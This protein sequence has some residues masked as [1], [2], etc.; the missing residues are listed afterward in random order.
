MN[1]KISRPF[2][3]AELSGNHN[4]KIERA[5]KLLEAAKKAG[6]NAAKLQTYTADTL[7]I[8]SNEP[9]FLITQ[10]PWA[11][12]NL[13]KLY[14]EAHTPW[15]W[16]PELFSKAQEL[17]I[18]IFS[19]P[20]DETAVDYLEKLGVARYKI[21]SFEIVHLPL[22]KYAAQTKKPMIISTGMA[23]LEE[24]SDAV[25]TAFNN[26]CTNLT[27]LHCVSSYPAVTK[28]CNLLTMIDI[29]KHFPDV[30]IGLSDHTLGTTVSVAAVAL[31][32]EVIEKHITLARSEGGVDAAFSL[33]P[34]EFKEL[35][36]EV[37]DSWLSLGTVNYCRAQSELENKVFRRSIYAV[38]DIY[39]GERLTK[40]NIRIIRPGFGLEPKYFD[41]IVG[42][43][44][45]KTYKK[46][47]RLYI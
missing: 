23:N 13:Y 21:A 5:F 24:I 22:I 42:T 8:D 18:E 43:E 28:D 19:S 11:G 2:I 3:I 40:K 32:A 33:E 7:T 15:N 26:G 20:F 14:Q 29:K 34:H 17:D 46:G 6:A 31:G 16:H 12:Y 25:E 39:P 38:E 44:S 9:D 10:G 35:C 30:A 36:Q 47:Q 45:K 1:S 27:L 41:E 37:Y 4:G